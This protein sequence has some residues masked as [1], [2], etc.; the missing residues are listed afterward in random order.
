MARVLVTRA[1]EDAVPICHALLQLG[2]R[3]VQVPLLQ[4]V[5]DIDALAPL[6]DEDF[7]WLVITSGAAADV[8][9]AAAP[10]AWLRARIGAVGPATA[11]K[12]ASMGRMPDLVPTRHLGVQLVRAM[13]D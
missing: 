8:L 2:H 5:W 12:L 3:P 7:D 6:A 10:G 4:R 9:A 11:R 1:A 13:G